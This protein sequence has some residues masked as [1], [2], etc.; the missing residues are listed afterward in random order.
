MEKIKQLNIQ[1][2][3]IV[4][5]VIQPIIDIITS[6]LVRHVSNVL[7]LGIFIR[8]IFMIAIVL[9]SFII[10]DKKYRIKIWHLFHSIYYSN[11]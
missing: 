2:L 3:F 7:T 4:F 8:T 6:V 9:Y 11:V 10:S 1:K 5:I